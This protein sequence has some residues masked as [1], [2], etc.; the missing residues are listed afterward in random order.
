MA[1]G[2][3]KLKS[4]FLDNF[5]VFLFS[6]SALMVLVISIITALFT[7]YIANYYIKALSARLLANSRS[8]AALVSAEE[9]SQFSTPEDMEKPG[10][11][12]LEERLIRFADEY[13]LMFVYYYYR[14]E[15][16]LIQSIIDND[17][18]EDSYSLRTEPMEAEPDIEFV[19]REGRAVSTDLGIYSIGW[20]GLLSAFAPVFDSSGNVAFIAGVDVLDMELLNARNMGRILSALLVMSLVFLIIAGFLIYFHYRKKESLLNNRFE[21][22]KVMSELA[23]I[24]ISLQDTPAL[25]NKALKIAGE[26]LGVTRMVIS[27]PEKDSGISVL[28]Y[29][30]QAVDTINTAPQKEGLN[31][32][33]RSFPELEPADGVVPVIFCNDISQDLRYAVMDIVGVRAFIMAPLYVDGKFWAVLVVEECIRAREWTESNRQ[34]VSTA[35]SVIAGAVM[36]DIRE[37]ARDAAL[38]QAKQASL[39]KGE[40]LANMSHEMRT[41]MNAI[42]GMTAIAKSSSDIE[43]KEYCIGKIEDASSHLLGVINDIL[44]MSKIEANRLKLSFDDFNFEKMLRKVVNV[45]NF[46]IEEKKQIFSVHI[47]KR[48][49]RNLYGDDQRLAQVITNLLSNAVKFT[50][51]E[52]VIVLDAKFID[53]TDRLY[54]FRISVSDSGIGISREQQE[55]LFHSFEQAETGTSRKYGGTGLGLAISKRIVEMMGGKIW[56]E[57]EPGK[58]STFRF[59]V[60]V[61]KGSELGESLLSPGIGWNN[62]Q[63]LVVDD[64]GD[65]LDYFR[66]IAGQLGFFCITAQS[67]EEALNIIEEKG[68]FDIYFIDWKMPGMNGIELSRRIKERITPPQA[69]ASGGKSRQEKSVVIMISATEWMLI[70]DE[71]KASGVDKFLPKP[72]FPSAIADIISQCLGSAAAPGSS[73][74]AGGAEGALAPDNFEG[75]WILL[76]ED[77]EINREIVI[78]LLEETRLGIDAAENGVEAVEMFENNP[79]KYDMIF[80]D[81]QMPVMDGYAA[82]KKIRELEALQASRGIARKA[83]PI[84]AMTANVFR[85]DIEKCF[86]AGMNGHIGK[87]LDFNDVM[88]RLREYVAR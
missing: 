72:L 8:A 6:G 19:Y 60:Q 61:E 79:G 29:V 17:T 14:N 73:A 33:T 84:I 46:R 65:I 51:E 50:P 12:E 3:K 7:Y 28:A 42:I 43:K 56:V 58:G 22:Q 66:D 10:Y 52:G 39:A 75:R 64:S 53:Q 32:V 54:T 27:R 55:R 34:L 57:S 9:L 59:T 49:P 80:M 88:A 18:G 30:W 21:Q 63:V 74:P 81:V 44:D 41:P 16:G 76:V 1:E 48:I 70:E 82:T 78:S 13:E 23:R 77:V 83:V 47:D 68:P 4:G 31:S 38:E 11:A 45:I 2:K 86:A 36:R 85:E 24:F 67:G 71:A 40:F 25:I 69:E 35:S 5:A 87:P 20:S 37:Q 26:F 15:D 62:V